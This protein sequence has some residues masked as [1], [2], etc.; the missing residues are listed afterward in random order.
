[1]PRHEDITSA[2]GAVK[3]RESGQFAP[4]QSGN[5]N[6]R[7]RKAQDVHEVLRRSMDET[8]VVNLGPKRKKI[9]KLKATTTQLA[10]KS[11]SGDPRATKMALD[12]LTK[13]EDR[14]SQIA[15]QLVLPGSDL[16]I[17]IRFLHRVAK[18][19]QSAEASI[20]APGT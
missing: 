20:D 18:I 9:S 4:G 2:G 6:G 16:E 12:L 7:P 17:V 10:N 13:G 11:A 14:Q 15:P 1:M 8:V 3:R 19:N 5:R